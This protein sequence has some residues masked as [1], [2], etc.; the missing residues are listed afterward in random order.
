MPTSKSET[1]DPRA[2]AFTSPVVKSADRT[3][4]TLE[5]LSQSTQP[6]TLAEMQ[7]ALGVPKSSL[8]GLLRTLIGRGWVE[9]DEWGTRYTIGLRALRVGTAY[10]DR[11]PV[12][13]IVTPILSALC[14]DLDETVHLARLDG[15]SVLYLASRESRHHLRV[16]SRIGRR[17][18]VHATAL[19]KAILA[20]RPW[21]EA[22]KIVSFPLERLTPHTVTKRAELQRELDAAAERGWA[23]EREQSTAGLGCF[24]VALAEPGEPAT[25]ALSCS[26]PLARLTD[27]HQK[28]IVA[29][30]SQA[31]HDIL[32]QLGPWS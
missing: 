7:R 25:D 14:R 29:T 21:P 2:A 22:S 1:L 24:A 26:V 10:L 13:Q 9:C 28:Q 4:D 8:H 17:L 11:D 31:R 32:N 27:S 30:L 16:G 3:I 5:L 23:G 15:S 18:P 6:L 20:S 19:G 12:V